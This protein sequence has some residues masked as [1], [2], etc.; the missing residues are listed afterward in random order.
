MGAKANNAV[1][2]DWDYKFHYNGRS[3]YRGAIKSINF[4]QMAGQPDFWKY[5]LNF[6]VVKNESMIRH[7][8]TKD[9][10]KEE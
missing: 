1:L 5:D 9:D 8:S 4:A 7:L 3:R 10:A 6:M 2:R